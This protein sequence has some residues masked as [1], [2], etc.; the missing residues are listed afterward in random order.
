MPSWIEFHDSELIAATQADTEVTVLLDAYV[1][2]WDDDGDRRK[3][4][5]W[6]QRVRVIVGKGVG[7]LPVITAPARIA[8]GRIAIGQ[9]VHR[10]LVRM[11]IQSEGA[12]SVRIQLATGEIVEI[13]GQP[14]RSESIGEGRQ[15]EELPADLW[16]GLSE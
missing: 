16:P 10:N 8:D 4:T 13:S 14:I 3:G 6:V 9:V 5:G 1:H 12:V 11:P 2:R 7:N 15:V